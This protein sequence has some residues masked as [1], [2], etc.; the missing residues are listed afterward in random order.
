MP[1]RPFF[2]LRYALPGYIFLIIVF[3][4]N[5]STLTA[6]LSKGRS[7]EIFGALLALLSGSPIGFIV[8]QIWYILFNHLLFGNYKVLPKINE[9]LKTKLGVKEIDDY[10]LQIFSDYVQ[11]LSTNKNMLNY[12]QRRWDLIHLFG[13]TISAMFIGLVFGIISDYIL[14]NYIAGLN[15]TISFLVFL[16]CIPLLVGLDRVLT[17]H[18]MARCII[19][20][21][22]ITNL[23]QSE[24]KNWERVKKII[25]EAKRDFEKRFCTSCGREIPISAKFCPY[26]GERTVEVKG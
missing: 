6:I 13:S 1:E 26:C 5:L 7:I 17:E 16:I 19:V 11:R 24:T 12:S 15:Y 9:F 14:S 8:S 23:E 21:D 10:H 18:S 4:T 3:F 20:R 22:T 25:I 2:S